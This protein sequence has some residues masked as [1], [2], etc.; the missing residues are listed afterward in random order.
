MQIGTSQLMHMNFA[1]FIR[2][3]VFINAL[4][5]HLMHTGPPKWIHMNFALFTRKHVFIKELLHHL[6]YTGTSQVNTYEI[7]FV[8]QETCVY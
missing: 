7:C 8:Y 2:K 4:L 1:L 6:M 5:H 3:L